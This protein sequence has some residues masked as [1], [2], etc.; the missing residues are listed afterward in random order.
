MGS[1]LKKSWDSS[2]STVTRLRFRSGGGTLSLRHQVQ[3]A[4]GA[5]SA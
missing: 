3:I 2:V 4:S 1:L 5:H